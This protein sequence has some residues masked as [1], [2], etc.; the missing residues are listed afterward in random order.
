MEW[1][2]ETLNRGRDFSVRMPAKTE[3]SSLLFS[4]LSVVLGFCLGFWL[5]ARI[6][7]QH[8]R[9]SVSFAWL[10]SI[11]LI[12]YVG[13]PAYFLFSG[14][15]LAGRMRRKA[16]LYP[17]SAAKAPEL[18]GMDS[19]ERIMLAAGMPPIRR[20]GRMKFISD[21]KE[22]YATLLDL[23]GEARQSIHIVTF[24]LGRDEVG[25]RL[26]EQ[27]TAKA[28]NG[29]K[30]HLL[31]DALGCYRT[32]G[33]FVRPLRN[34]GGKV[35]IFAPM[36]PL[37]RKWSA[38]L[39]NHRKMILVDGK[40]ALI[41]GMNLGSKYMGPGSDPH[42]WLDSTFLLEGFAVRDLEEIFA[43]DWNFATE[44]AHWIERPRSRGSSIA[45]D[46]ESS[47]QIAASG[48]DV[49]DEPLYDA[50]LTAFMNAKERIWIVTPYFI[51]DESITHAIL[52]QARLGRD[53]RVLIPKR[54]DHLLADLARRPFLRRMR[55]C[56]VKIFLYPDGMIHAKH[57]IVDNI[58]LA[59]SMNLDMRSLYLNYEIGVLIR[60]AEEVNAVAD[61]VRLLMERS[62]HFK[63]TNAGN[64]QSFL[65]DLSYLISPLL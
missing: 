9:P 24:I 13:V 33:R 25:A 19:L 51:P 34:A 2:P 5:V 46:G 48:P 61:W 37:R 28:A 49:A 55:E 35:G 7:R 64:A 18:A 32:K 16:K 10:M 27:L 52:L 30:V 26:V 17:K 11:V 43:D 57:M 54:S 8:L 31:L 42:R 1:N 23:I 36:L 63:K 62:E 59:G 58:A 6:L 29:V 60:S 53:V 12:P 40:K 65:E 4:H 21:G 45:G 3:I 14:R 47:V 50:I 56:G 38:N 41:G 39:R 22:A 20:G 44:E 15:K